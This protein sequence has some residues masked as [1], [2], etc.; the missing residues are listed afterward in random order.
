MFKIMPITKK[1]NQ[2]ELEER[3][4]LPLLSVWQG[5]SALA[6]GD[7]VIIM[8][9]D[10]HHT[11]G[12]GLVIIIMTVMVIVVMMMTTTLAPCRSALVREA[13]RTR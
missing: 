8:M 6:E 5:W 9:I 3:V 2:P 12:G 4:F 10:D 13:L 11:V 7:L 1:G